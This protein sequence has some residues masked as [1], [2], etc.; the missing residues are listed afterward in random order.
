MFSSCS[1]VQR[2]TSGLGVAELGSVLLL[3][4]YVFHNI[5]NRERCGLDLWDSGETSLPGCCEKGSE[6]SG[7]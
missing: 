1:E 5:A 3:T 4:K 2:L 6:T 7:G